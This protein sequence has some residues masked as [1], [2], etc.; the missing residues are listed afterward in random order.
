MARVADEGARATA[1]VLCTDLVGSTELLVGLGEADF[2]AFRRRHFDALRSALVDH[3][4][5]EIKTLG[6][7]M[8]V[9]FGSA[10][11]AL[12][13][14]VTMQQAVHRPAAD[15][16]AAIAIRVGLALGDVAFEDSDVFGTPV[17]QAARLTAA[18]RGGQILAT[19][20]VAAVAGGRSRTACTE[21]APMTL[22]GLPE[23]VEVCEVAWD[24]VAGGAAEAGIT[25]AIGVL[26]SIVLVRDGVVSALRSPRRRLLLAILVARRGRVVPADE[27]VEALWGDALPADPAAT[28]QSQVS[29]LRRALGSAAGWVETVGVGYRLVDGPGRV[30]AARFGELVAQARAQGDRPEEALRAVEAAL[31]LWRGRAYLEVADHAGLRVAAADLE[32]LRADAEELRGELLLVLDRAAEAARAMA[33]LALTQ[34]FRERPVAL[35][36]R[37]LARDGRNA[38]ALRVFE[39]FRRLLGEELGLDPSPELRAVQAEV[40]RPAV[41]PPRSGGPGV[42]L[43]ANSFVGRDADLHAV[44]EY[45]G[46]ARLVTLTGPGGMGKTRLALHVSV[47]VADRYPDGVYVCELAALTDPDAVPAA[48]ATTLGIKEGAGRT[49]TQALVEFLRAKHLLLVVDNCEH[50]LPGA[51][52]LI[53]AVLAQA[54][55]V[56]VLA[57]SRERLGAEGEQRFLVD[58]LPTPAG[59][60]VAGPAVVLFADRAAAVRPDF[61]LTGANLAA[62]C[63]LCRRLDGLPL[64]IELA[65]SRTV[66][67]SPAEI[68]A[69]MADRLDRLSDR[70]RPVDRHRSIEAVIG[71]SYDLVDPAEQA[72][73]ERLAVF[74]GGFTVEAAAAVVVAAVDDLVDTL[75]ALV[76]LSFLR[77][78]DAAGHTRFSMLEPV[79]QYAEA[80][81]RDQGRL[82]ETR[83][84]H[85]AWFVRFA[86]TADNGMR[87]RE[88]ALWVRA[89]GHEL[90]NLRTA[91][92]WCLEHD[93]DGAIRLAIAVN[94][95]GMFQGTAEVLRWAQATVDRFGG[96]E[97]P[98]L[99]RAVFAAGFGAWRRGDMRLARALGE[100]SVELAGPDRPDHSFWAWW[101]LLCTEM[102]DGDHEAAAAGAQR[103]V[104]FGREAGSAYLEAY[105]HCG[106]ALAL[107]VA[108]RTDEALAVL[109]AASHLL[110]SVD[111]P[112]LHAYFQYAA[113]EARLES[114][115]RD[116]LPF[117]RRARDTATAVGN[118]F[119]AD[120]AALSAV[121]CAA[122]LGD[123]TDAMAGYAGLIDRWH[124]P[125]SWVQQ[126][127]T[128][129][130]LIEML[131]NLGDHEPAAVLYGALMTTTT[132]SPLIGADA[133]RLAAAAATLR[134]RLGDDRF[135]GLHAEGAALG[136]DRAVA[137]ALRVVRSSSGRGAG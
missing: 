115:P 121:S 81:L 69:E 72:V 44:I 16:R 75:T 57:T 101:L 123:T 17:V 25:D 125:G 80:R 8:L 49:I 34:P 89:F 15:G 128:I 29:R 64:A 78:R 54:P 37:A 111:N 82:E 5:R 90:A 6:D 9:V 83:A 35:R 79:R 39:G 118:W 119:F 127:L 31:D 106:C 50:V 96:N 122:R 13:C 84:R 10:A 36:M 71:W 32:E 38:E 18:A 70:R 56:D 4:G 59:D 55:E 110:R 7:G 77:V 51:T 24:P 105:G 20:L 104:A 76:E 92:R 130:T 102:I 134:A 22:K 33:A 26:G 68:V 86:E 132:G 65:A 117:L 46:R 133:E 19:A 41:D 43:P 120:I 53:T 3:G 131:T 85:A 95:L 103:A 88:E 112:S 23:P 60:D 27:L 135:A 94:L 11:D 28:L 126:W 21:L 116:A 107:G 52:R 137:Y 66:S 48:V 136:D 73:F 99:S 62:V 98:E 100:R 87:G 63:D 30:D 61:R 67:R 108:G 12:S 124:R 42:A 93:E 40:L 114:A 2:D 14:A 97:H 129:R 47:A 45:L 91:H 113:G 74:T 1:A 58:P 109:A